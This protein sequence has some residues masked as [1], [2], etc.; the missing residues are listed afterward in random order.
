M[1][2][3]VVFQ[4]DF[5]SLILESLAKWRVYDYFVDYNTIDIS[6]IGDIYEYLIKR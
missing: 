1:V 4:K 2:F 3:W 5:Q 6:D